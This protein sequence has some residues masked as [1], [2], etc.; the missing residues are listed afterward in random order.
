[1]TLHTR[2]LHTHRHR[3]VQLSLSFSFLKKRSSRR[4]RESQ[5][6]KLP[7]LKK[8]QHMAALSGF[9]EREGLLL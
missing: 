8:Q 7:R 1:M 5:F 3:S 2:P 4:E 9:T 6:A